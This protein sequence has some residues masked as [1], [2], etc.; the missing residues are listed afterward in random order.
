MVTCGDGIANV[1]R[2]DLLNVHNS[3]GKLATVTGSNPTSR[4]GELKINQNQVESFNEKPK[5]NGSLMKGGQFV[6]NNG[7]RV[8]ITGHTG[9]KGSG[10]SLWLRDL[11]SSMT[12][13]ALY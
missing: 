1:N 5:G 3:H 9:C 10:L 13:G 11:L 7:T 2:Y 8:L 6:F 4:F 12:T